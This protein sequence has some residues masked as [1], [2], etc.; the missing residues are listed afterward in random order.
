MLSKAD[1]MFALRGLDPYEG[2]CDGE[3]G[4]DGCPCGDDSD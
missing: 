1:V 2:P 4:R 3:S